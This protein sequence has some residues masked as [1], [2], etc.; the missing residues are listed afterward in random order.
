MFVGKRLSAG[1]VEGRL[2]DRN[3][4]EGHERGKSDAG[5]CPQDYTRLERKREEGE[6]NDDV[7]EKEQDGFGVSTLAPQI[8]TPAG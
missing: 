5:H 7:E 3:G 2:G 4:G 8:Q 1:G 6:T